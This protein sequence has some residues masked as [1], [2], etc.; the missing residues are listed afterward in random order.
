MGPGSLMHTNYQ[1]QT[2]F[3]LA[4]GSK[5]LPGRRASQNRNGSIQIIEVSIDIRIYNH[6][7]P[8]PP[9]HT[10]TQTNSH[11]HT[12]ILFALQT[13]PEIICWH[14]TAV[15]TAAWAALAAWPF[16]ALPAKPRRCIKTNEAGRATP[17]REVGGMRQDSPAYYTTPKKH[18]HLLFCTRACLSSSLP[19][20]E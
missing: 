3:T 13:F 9:T 20:K 2:L 16:A 17:L 12:H 7:P 6:P 11:T 10:H 8:H 14:G 1:E 19:D 18:G 5:V 4:A 15:G